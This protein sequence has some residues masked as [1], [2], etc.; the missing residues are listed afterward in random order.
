MT[1]QLGK[2][3]QTIIDLL[4]DGQWHCS[5]EIDFRDYRRRVGELIDGDNG[6][7][8][9]YPIQ[10]ELCRGRCGRNHGSSVNWLRLA[11]EIAPSNG[12]SVVP[13]K[14]PRINDFRASSVKSACC[15][16]AVA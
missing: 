2:Q 4:S 13:R 10:K 1:G 11:I 3:H 5:N 15:P 14:T 6:T 16:S 8:I 12:D 9:K 7:K